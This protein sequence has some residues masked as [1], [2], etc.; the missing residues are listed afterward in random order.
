L[1]EEVIEKLIKIALKKIKNDRLALLNYIVNIVL[2][3]YINCQKKGSK[4]AIYQQK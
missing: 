4:N 2:R 3:E 1:P